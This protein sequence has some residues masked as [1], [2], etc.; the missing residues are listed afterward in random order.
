MKIA[1]IA[2]LAGLLAVL[3]TSSALAQGRTPPSQD[4][5]KAQRAAK[6]AEAWFTEAGWIDDYDVAR[7]KAKASGK[8][9]LAYFTRTYST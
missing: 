6:V 2:V 9:I 5:L 7:E 3:F 8:L 4:Q 1:G